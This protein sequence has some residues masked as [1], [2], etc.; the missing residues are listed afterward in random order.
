MPEA[1]KT[2]QPFET[3]TFTASDAAISYA[4]YGEQGADAPILI[5]VHET[6]GSR[7]AFDKLVGVLA[8]YY[9][10]ITY[11]LR[12]HGASEGDAE[13]ATYQQ[14]AGDLFAMLNCLQIGQA[15]FLGLGDGAAIVLQLA[16]DHQER[17]AAI[18]TIS[19][20]L[21]IAGLTTQARLSS[22]IDKRVGGL[23]AGFSKKAGDTPGPATLLGVSE[24]EVAPLARV[25]ADALLVTGDNDPV[26]R[27]HSK[28]ISTTLPNA[29]LRFIDDGGR[30][31]LAEN[32]AEVCELVRHWLV[33]EG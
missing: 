21:S 27:E 30:D 13:L 6:G 3:A 18:V 23:L 33:D 2:L 11:D 16:S 20:V 19:G 9:Q 10:V 28:A 4:R 1:G 31:I 29:E 15:C 26:K 8:P 22:A 24:V 17:V 12:G 5:L 32:S 7:D 14:H 25:Q